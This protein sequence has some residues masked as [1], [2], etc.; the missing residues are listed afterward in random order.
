MVR[1]NKRSILLS[2][3]PIVYFVFISSFAVRNERTFLPLVPFIALFASSLL[4]FLIGKIPRLGGTVLRIAAA[5]VLLLLAAFGF[6]N[7]AHQSISD[8]LE[9]IRPDGRDTAR[10]WIEHYLPKGSAIAIESYTPYVSPS[11]YSV[12]GVTKMIDHSPEW[13]A[14]QGTEYL[15]FGQAAF[16]R[17][18]YESEKYP[19]EV[20]LYDRFFEVTPL[21]ARFDDGGYEVQIR[22]IP[23]SLVSDS[24]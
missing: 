12:M 9:L 6:G 21:V 8:T 14:E 13:Y 18:Y 2:V 19:D 1:R 15:V 3:F 24:E 11:D 20:A 16:G 17:Y 5:A 7:S 23:D 22:Q 4:V 10:E